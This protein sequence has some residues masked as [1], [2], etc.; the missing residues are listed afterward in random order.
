MSGIAE[1]LLN[2]GFAI[3][4]SDLRETL[5]TRRLASLGAKV[6]TGHASEN[7]AGAEVVVTSSAVAASNPEVIEAHRRS[8]PVIPRAEMLAELM[9]LKFSVA[10]AGSHGKTTVTSMVAVMLTEAGLDPTAVIGGRLDVFGSS[11]R[12]GKGELMVAE[13]DESDRSFLLLLPSIAVVTN[14]DREHLDH[15]RDLDEI[16]DAFVSFMNKTPFYGAVIACSDAPW[17]QTLEAV[18]PRLR[19]RLIT[20]GTEEGATITADRIE[21]TREGSSFEVRHSGNRL[22]D[23]R[24][25]VPG[26]HNVQNALAAAG[27]GLELGLTPAQ[28]QQGLERFRGADRRFQVKAEVD[29]V[30]VID[31]YGH[32]PTEIRATLDA[33]HSRGAGRIWAIFQPHRFSRTRFLMDD[34]A[35]AFEGCERVY[36]LD[37]YPAGEEPI[38][39]V[40]SERLAMRMREMGCAGARY[41]PREDDVVNEIVAEA[42]PGLTVLTIGAGSVWKLADALAGALPRA[43]AGALTEKQPT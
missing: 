37:I 36:I 29:G 16:K 11:A 33:A 4:G 34:F 3:S 30:T 41:A 12:L 32:H 22:V 10:I 26:R 2:L 42:V 9:R 38:P 15:Y 18:R 1:L 19:R 27:V 21:L 14:I 31:D 35:S 24:L 6:F 5:V 28:I 20:Y 13:A 7:V 8:I 25:H 40:S 39:G 23:I 17:R 43:L